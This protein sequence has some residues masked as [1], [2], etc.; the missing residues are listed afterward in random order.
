MGLCFIPMTHNL[1]HFVNLVRQL[2]HP[3]PARLVIKQTKFRV[4]DVS[5]ILMKLMDG[6]GVTDFEWIG[7]V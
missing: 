2:K 3:T 1:Q 5:R 7:V 4:A 6:E